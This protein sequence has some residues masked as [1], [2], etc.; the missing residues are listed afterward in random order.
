MSFL[1]PL[2]KRVVAWLVPWLAYGTIRVLGRAV[3]REVIYPEIP[4]SLWKRGIPFIMAF[5]HA[6]LLMMHWAYRGKNMSFLIS[7]HRDGQIMGKAGKLL[8]HHPI[9]GSTTRKG[10]SAF[11][12]MIKALQNGSDVV[13][14]PDGPKGPRQKAQIGVIEL[15]RITGSP[16]VPVTFS[17]SKKIVFNSWD[18]FVLPYPF[19]RGVFI[20]GDPIHVDHEG[21]RTHLEEKRLL[22]ESRLN[23]ITE[24]A[25]HYFDSQAF[26]RA[27]SRNSEFKS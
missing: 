14:A 25:D 1:K 19:S 17:A 15:S 11:K 16:I 18:R 6:R 5:W 20:W 4:G 24:K 12:N 26:G 2:K 3:R 22:L 13:I 21:N 23:E 7:F 8:G 9:V 10:F 27:M